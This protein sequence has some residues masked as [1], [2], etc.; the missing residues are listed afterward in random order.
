M[1]ATCPTHVI[2]PHLMILTISDEAPNYAILS[3]LRSLPPLGTPFSDINNDKALKI[4]VACSTVASSNLQQFTE[5][6]TVFA[7]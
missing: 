1:N 4:T 5:F 3:I 7:T 2:L 6:F